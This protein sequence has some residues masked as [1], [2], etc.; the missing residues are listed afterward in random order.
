M[1]S[2]SCGREIKKVLA[3]AHDTYTSLNQSNRP[4]L[5][6]DCVRFLCEECCQKKVE[7]WRDHNEGRTEPYLIETANI[8][9]SATTKKDFAYKVLPQIIS[10][11]KNKHNSSWYIGKSVI[12]ESLRFNIK[13]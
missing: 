11:F 9:V 4:L 1:I 6:G 13:K 8:N 7:W 2:C 12:K 10:G 5:T 3:I